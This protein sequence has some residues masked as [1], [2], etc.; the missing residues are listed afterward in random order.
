M[1]C[2]SGSFL[3]EAFDVID[4]YVMNM[5]GQAGPNPQSPFPKAEGGNLP[6][7][8]GE[9]LGERSDILIEQGKSKFCKTAF[10]R[11]QR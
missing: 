7:R 11:G 10:W 2:G 9:G 6:L 4:K 3:I 5:R 8:V 1:A